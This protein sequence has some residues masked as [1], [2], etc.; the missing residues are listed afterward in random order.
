MAPLDLV[1]SSTHASPKR[2][3]KE[4]KPFE[5][6]ESTAASPKRPRKEKKQS[7]D[8]EQSLLD[9]IDLLQSGKD[10]V[11]VAASAKI[12][13]YFHQRSPNVGSA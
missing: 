13:G 10:E 8:S 7:R 3:R 11:A 12:V 9:L 4:K 5:K 6:P 2:P 1:D